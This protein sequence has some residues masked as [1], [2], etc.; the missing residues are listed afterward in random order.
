MNSDGSVIKQESM[1]S[2]VSDYM[3]RL[4]RENSHTEDSV[5]DEDDA[6][7]FSS[8]ERSCSG[9]SFNNHHQAVHITGKVIVQ[10]RGG[11]TSSTYC[12]ANSRFSEQSMVDLTHRG[13]EV[14]MTT[15]QQQQHHP[16]DVTLNNGESTNQAVSTNSLTTTDVP[17]VSEESRVGEVSV[18]KSGH[19]NSTADSGVEMD[20]SN[21][22]HRPCEEFVFVSA[23]DL[24]RNSGDGCIQMSSSLS[25]ADDDK[26]PNVAEQSAFHDRTSVTNVDN[27][28]E[29]K[30]PLDGAA[31]DSCTAVSEA[32][33]ATPPSVDS[34]S[35]SGSLGG[36]C[37]LSSQTD[38]DCQE[39][40]RDIV[41]SQQHSSSSSSSLSSSSLSSSSLVALFSSAS[42]HSNNVTSQHH[43][44]TQDA[45]PTRAAS[46]PSSECD[47]A[48]TDLPAAAASCDISDA[49]P[50]LHNFEKPGVLETP[51]G[52]TENE[53]EVS[54]YV[55]ESVSA[56]KV[57]LIST[58]DGSCS[59][60]DN[61][62]STRAQDVGIKTL[63]ARVGAETEEGVSQSSV[64]QS[65]TC[66]RVEA[67]VPN[68]K[69]DEVTT[70]SEAATG[71]D[72]VTVHRSVN[73]P[74][75]HDADQSK[76]S[77]TATPVQS[78]LADD[79]SVNNNNSDLHATQQA[80]PSDS[81]SQSSQSNAGV[82]SSNA[83][84]VSSGRVGLS[85]GE[86]DTCAS[87][88]PV[89][90]TSNEQDNEAVSSEDVPMETESPS[91]TQGASV[92]AADGR[93]PPNAGVVSSQQNHDSSLEEGEIVDD[94][95]EEEEDAG[96]IQQQASSSQHQHHHHHGDGVASSSSLRMD[97]GGA[98]MLSQPDD[99]RRDEAAV[100]SAA[101]ATSSS[102][103]DN[104]T[105][106]SSGNRGAGMF[107]RSGACRDGTV[108][109]RTVE[110]STSAVT[111]HDAAV[112][113]G[114]VDTSSTARWQH[115]QPITDPPVSSANMPTNSDQ[116]SMTNSHN[117]QS[118][119]LVD[120]TSNLPLSLQTAHPGGSDYECGSELSDV[121]SSCLQSEDS[122]GECASS[123]CQGNNAR[124]WQQQQQVT[125]SLMSDLANVSLT[126]S[127]A[128][129][130]FLDTTSGISSSAAVDSVSCT[131]TNT[132][133]S[134]VTSSVISPVKGSILKNAIPSSSQML[135]LPVTPPP[136]KKKVGII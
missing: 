100:Q 113:D 52:Q 59:S 43:H 102:P 95:D 58:T 120:S 13:S 40:D 89:G 116:I 136:A 19:L 25:C 76:D 133:L 30:L 122:L 4:G 119:S 5:T 103:S 131:T 6:S 83:G 24:P 28:D 38:S 56:Q 61:M 34:S 44:T 49:E 9:D 105:S 39:R 8:R 125:S 80:E 54:S 98:G 71:S 15:D 77:L 3:L 81:S 127:S 16:K 69:E 65:A 67:Q 87:L 112:T 36:A 108:T 91:T 32:A 92:S 118:E 90:G 12:D 93:S 82:V 31:V 101:S 111:S 72:I 60:S 33:S 124:P 96:R 48:Q 35:K 97:V 107:G 1:E 79:N 86:A 132:T 51:S 46:A 10:P 22:S 129:P 75:T 70:Q 29:H 115:H 88:P 41:T 2:E 130:S 110:S 62:P 121:S 117:R 135:Q 18:S 63:V 94:D 84:V 126:S 114:Q 73:V 55:T 47:S 17:S 42:P 7:Q 123:S 74:N 104:I 45:A 66:S 27:C 99:G 85:R 109:E 64:H 14:A 23:S 57:P 26:T 53:A 50:K 11:V 20:L 128:S 68:S 106:S 78:S 21:V 134:S 37:V